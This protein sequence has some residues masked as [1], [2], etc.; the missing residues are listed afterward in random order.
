MIFEK[1]SNVGRRLTPQIKT[2]PPQ[3]CDGLANVFKRT[4]RRWLAKR[5]N[6]MTTIHPVGKQAATPQTLR[7][8]SIRK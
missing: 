7:S 3:S 1:P 6:G 8:V 4:N 5:A 2:R